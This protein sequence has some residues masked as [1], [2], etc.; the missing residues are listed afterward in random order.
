M[1]RSNRFGLGVGIVL[2][3]ID[4]GGQS[5][6]ALVY[7]VGRLALMTVQPFVWPPTISMIVNILGNCGLT[8][9]MFFRRGSRSRTYCH[10]HSGIAL[11]PS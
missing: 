2:V 9:L 11:K 4:R 8:L 5:P 1:T 6:E 3:V 7:L 10:F